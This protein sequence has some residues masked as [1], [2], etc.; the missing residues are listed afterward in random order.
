MDAFGRQMTLKLILSCILKGY[1]MSKTYSFEYIVWVWL[2]Y[3]EMAVY[4]CF[5]YIYWYMDTLFVTC[6]IICLKRIQIKPRTFLAHFSIHV[7]ASGGKTLATQTDSLGLIDN[8]SFWWQ[9]LIP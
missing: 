7:S 2:G 1:Y 5:D 9:G 3:N 4:I 8:S 6:F